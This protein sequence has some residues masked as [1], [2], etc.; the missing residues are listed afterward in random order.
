MQQ[1]GSKYFTRRSPHTYT[2]G[3]KRSSCIST[4]SELCNVAYQIKGNHGS[5]KFA[6]GDINSTSLPSLTSVLPGDTSDSRNSS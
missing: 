4:F 5:K 3:V 6:T 2:L 1:H